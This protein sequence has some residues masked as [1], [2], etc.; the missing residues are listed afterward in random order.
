MEDKNT[1]Y[2]IT[3][4]VGRPIEYSPEELALKANEYFQ[5]VLENPLIEVDFRGKY[6][7]E[8]KLPKMRPFTIEGFC[9]FAGIIRQTFLNYEKREEFLEVVSKIRNI[10]ENQQYEGAASGFLNSNIV[11]RKLGLAD[12]KENE[13]KGS[14]TFLDA[15]KNA[16]G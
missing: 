4:K 12:K 7:E 5:W 6:L 3:N 10:I 8:V 9:I 1:L 15:L 14:L 11:A 2:Q 13:I 16:R